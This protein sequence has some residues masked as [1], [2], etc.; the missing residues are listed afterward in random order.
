[1]SESICSDGCHRVGN[2]IIGDVVWDDKR[3]GESGV[4]V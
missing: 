2:A 3:A 1:M 4:V